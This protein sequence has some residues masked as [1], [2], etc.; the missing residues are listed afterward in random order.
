MVRLFHGEAFFLQIYRSKEFN[1]LFPLRESLYSQV[2]L[3]CLPTQE[4][5]PPIQENFSQVEFL[6]K[7]IPYWNI[8]YDSNKSKNIVFISASSDSAYFF[9]PLWY[10][11]DTKGSKPPTFDEK[12]SLLLNL[13]KCNFHDPRLKKILLSKR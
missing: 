1:K 13:L 2:L 11:V 10:Y 6:T 7:H 4:L 8:Y 12:Q 9:E 5:V 3:W